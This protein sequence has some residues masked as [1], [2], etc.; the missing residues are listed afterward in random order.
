MPPGW[1]GMLVANAGAGGGAPPAAVE[2][3]YC[4]AAAA[5]I[6]K[7]IRECVE[8]IFHALRRAAHREAHFGG[9]FADSRIAE[10]PQAS[11][12]LDQ[13]P[14]AHHGNVVRSRG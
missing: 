7:E 9:E 8:R 4:C 14:L 13:I 6:S 3:T 10:L 5:V 11:V 2:I 1:I 12:R